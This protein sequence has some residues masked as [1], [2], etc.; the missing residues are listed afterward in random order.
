MLHNDALRS[1]EPLQ[2]VSITAVQDIIVQDRK[3]SVGLACSACS[4]RY[5]AFQ[6][7]N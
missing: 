2:H 7:K 6:A 1:A 5:H 3:P 4:V